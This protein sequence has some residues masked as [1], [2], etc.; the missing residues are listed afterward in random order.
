ME[1]KLPGTGNYRIYYRDA[2]VYWQQ[3][4][5]LEVSEEQWKKISERIKADLKSFS[6]DKTLAF[7]TA[8]AVCVFIFTPVQIIVNI[9]IVEN[10]LFISCFIFYPST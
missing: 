10:N 9:R 7:D 8:Y 4:E 6:K 1:N 5:Q 2:H 3:V